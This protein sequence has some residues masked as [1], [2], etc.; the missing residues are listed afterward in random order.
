MFR[1]LRIACTIISAVFVAFV[2]P[3]GAIFDW[4][5]AIVCAAVAFAFYGLMLY[6]KRKQ[7]EIEGE[8]DFSAPAPSEKEASPFEEGAKESQNTEENAE[9]KGENGI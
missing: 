5:W 2:I 9:E 7:I 8:E 6:F 3:V 4:I 1:K